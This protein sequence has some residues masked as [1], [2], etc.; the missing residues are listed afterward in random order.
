MYVTA[1]VIL[2]VAAL[3]VPV[4]L[5]FGGQRVTGG[6]PSSPVPATPTSSPPPATS[7]APAAPGTDVSAWSRSDAT[8]TADPWGAILGP[9]G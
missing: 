2:S 4:D 5:P 1:A 3:A 9:G 6:P 7:A 8:T